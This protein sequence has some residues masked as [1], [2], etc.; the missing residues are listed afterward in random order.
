MKN[1]APNQII[2]TRGEC[3]SNQFR[4]PLCMAFIVLLLVL[5]DLSDPESI[6]IVLGGLAIVLFL[7]IFTILIP[8][9]NKSI[10]FSLHETGIFVRSAGKEYDLAWSQIEKMYEDKTSVWVPGVLFSFRVKWLYIKT[11]KPNSKRIRCTCL[12]HSSKFFIY[13]K[14]EKAVAFYSHGKVPYVKYAEYRKRHT[15][16]SNPSDLFFDFDS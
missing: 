14:I 1:S 7:A 4:W 8:L 6:A 5:V 2:V 16:K 3:K 10:L 9:R 15:H 12:V 11:K 13:K